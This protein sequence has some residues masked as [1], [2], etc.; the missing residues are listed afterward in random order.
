[1]KPTK[2][3]LFHAQE[4]KLEKIVLLGKGGPRELTPQVG[5]EGLV[6]ATAAAEIAPGAYT[7]DVSFSNE[8]DRRATSLYRLETGGT[9]TPSR[10]SRR[11]T[12]ASPSPA[13]TSRPSS[14]RIRSRSSCRR[15]TK[16]SPTP[17]SS[18][19]P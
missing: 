17:R 7:L 18:D 4:M 11:S 9:P 10:S 6:T 16:P 12:R 13:G 1:M 5:D 15:L 2:T 14:F 8:F 3:I 19:K